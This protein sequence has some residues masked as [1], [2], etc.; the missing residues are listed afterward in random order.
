MG[1]KAAVFL[2][3]TGCKIRFNRNIMGCKVTSL[4]QVMK[5]QQDLIGT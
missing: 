1:C 2:T 5:I 3:I 4:L